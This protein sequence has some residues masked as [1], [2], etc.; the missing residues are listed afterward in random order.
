MLDIVVKNLG[1]RK[2]RS[3][4]CILAVMV[5]VFL[6]GTT[7]T[8]NNW[9]YGTMTS[10]LAKYMGKIYIQ[11]GG[12]SYPP[13]DSSISQ[14]TAQVILSRGD[15]E[16]N[17][18]ESAPLI[19]IRT[20]RGMMPFLPAKEMV[21]GVSAGR[22]GVLLG[23]AQASEGTNR[24]DAGEQGD[25]TIL[26]E[27]MAESYE[28][29]VGQDV[30]INGQT[31]RVIGVLQRSSMDSANIAAIMPL[32]A[33]QRI[34]AKEGT[35]SAVL[36]TPNDVNQTTEIAAALRRDYPA[37]EV[38]TQDDMLTEAESVMRMPMRYMSTMSVTG[39]VVAV[40]VIMSTMVMAVMERTR[41]FGTLRAIGGRRRLI[42]GMVFAEA[43]LLALIGGLPSIG[44]VLLMSRWMNTSLP[45]ATQLLQIVGF[46]AGAAVLAASYPAWRAARVEPMEALRYE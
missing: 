23:N 24:F 11:Q 2:M 44:L 27:K 12:S 13:I 42:V 7:L 9:M 5:S 26:G 10:E 20:E 1:E 6:N 37:L 36:L 33:V 38:V 3:L 32:E 21:I 40:A 16:L 8:M 28:A 4:L 25:V 19:F 39:L 34:F 22:E 31:V 14:E 17:T 45:S 35:V 43:L 30:T 15:L 18:T 29:S 46:T 41:E